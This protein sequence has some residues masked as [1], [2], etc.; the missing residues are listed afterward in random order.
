A[1]RR[2]F[3]QH[4]ADALRD[5]A[6]DLAL[7]HGWIDQSA[8]VLDGDVPLHLHDAG[9]GIDVHDRAVSAAGPAAFAAVV[10]GLDLELGGGA[11]AGR[12]RHRGRALR[13]LGDGDRAG[14]VAAYPDVAVGDQEVLRADLHEVRR[15]SEHLGLELPGAVQR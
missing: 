15:E 5:A 1:V 13:D 4:R 9:L 8:A 10:R 6:P 2:S 11:V 7:D 12:T 3:Q 14:R